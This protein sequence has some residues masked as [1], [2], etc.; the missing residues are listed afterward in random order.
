M[1]LPYKFL[2]LSPVLLFAACS[3]HPLPEDF[4]SLDTY[5]IVRQVRCEARG[6]IEQ[7]II[8]ALTNVK[9][10]GDY[11]KAHPDV[12]AA[13]QTIARALS[14]DATTSGPLGKL[15]SDPK[16][17]INFSA[18]KFPENDKVVVDKFKMS[19]VAYNFTFDMTEI[20][21]FDTAFDFL[22]LLRHT[23]IGG[24]LN[25]G[26]DRRRDNLRT[27]N[28]TDTFIGL[29]EMNR[30]GSYCE[31]YITVHNAVYP[32]TGKIGLGEVFNT[33]IELSSFANLTT[34]EAGKGTPAISDAIAFTTTL[35]GSV[36]P[37]VT[38]A[39]AFRGAQL[40]DAQLT[41][42]ASRTDV[43]KLV[44]AVAEPPPAKKTAERLASTA[45]TGG[46][47]A[48]TTPEILTL[49]DTFVTVS[50]S[51]AE[52]AAARAVNQTIF[53]FEFGRLGAA[54]ALAT[55]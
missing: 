51:P 43:H 3:T 26:F 45:R 36:A 7:V 15:V 35:S 53:R 4:A 23:I 18:L 5:G 14:S 28:V 17:V 54:A 30:P 39:A 10:R 21:N 19:A 40:A 42:T 22:G 32:I 6:G 29:L 13:E 20:N 44:I 34:L 11:W 47:T 33:F 16:K 25:A 8:Q 55:Q 49:D 1:R 37:K 41:A 38:L 24:A 9:V 2:S 50:G 12:A 27:F 31:N 52:I 46:E 48:T